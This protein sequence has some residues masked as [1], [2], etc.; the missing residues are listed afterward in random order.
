VEPGRNIGR[1]QIVR[2][3]GQGGIG[4]V[5][6]A[7]DT[8]L[9]RYV[10]L[11]LLRDD[12]GLPSE[13]RNTLSAR[14]RDT[15]QA[16]SAVEHPN[17]ATL[18]DMGDDLSAGVFLVYEYL[19]GPTLRQKIAEGPID[20]IVVGRVARA[21]GDALTAAHDAGLVHG[22]VKPE[23]V[24]L[25]P[26]G[27]KLTDLGLA[28]LDDTALTTAGVGLGTPAY[29]APET[30]ARTELGAATDQFSLAATLFEA[31][32]ARRAFP[33]DDP[34]TIARRI[35][36]EPAPP[37]PFASAEP[38]LVSRLDAVL[39]RA[40]SKEPEQRYPSCRAFGEALAGAVQAPA[41]LEA[42]SQPLSERTGSDRSGPRSF[43]PRATRRVH[44]VIAAIA[45]LV[46]AALVVFGKQDPVGVSMKHVADDFAA[47]NASVRTRDASTHH[48]TRPA[49]SG[50]AS[51]SAPR[52]AKS[53]DVAPPS[54][55]GAETEQ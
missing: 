7:K 37:L 3:I 23:N 2:P 53:A 1:Y 49:T 20:P 39:A 38:R 4:R 30:L 36:N 21:L 32:C 22:D 34:L 25:S 29:T 15:A 16:A 43:I 13:T 24:I 42:P 51:P 46:I 33:G 10:A 40:L 44:N 18:H 50:A 6:L 54:D 35:T 31:I 52:P 11:K 5:F 45:L 47:A 27:P 17:L 12:I 41:V 28:H 55:S 8:V 26:H 14:L 48:L 9:G 19:P